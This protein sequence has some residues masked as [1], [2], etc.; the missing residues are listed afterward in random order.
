MTNQFLK[1]FKFTK[2]FLPGARLD[3]LE[4]QALWVAAFFKHRS[5]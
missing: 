1:K 5:D 2:S 4:P 3:S